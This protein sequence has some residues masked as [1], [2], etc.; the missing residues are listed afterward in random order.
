MCSLEKQDCY[1][2]LKVIPLSLT[3]SPNC[4]KEVSFLVEHFKAEPYKNLQASRF[5]ISLPVSHSNFRKTGKFQQGGHDSHKHFEDEPLIMTY[6]L[7]L[8]ISHL[9]IP[10]YSLMLVLQKGMLTF[11]IIWISKILIMLKDKS[12]L[13]DQMKIQCGCPFMWRS[14]LWISVIKG[15]LFTFISIESTYKAIYIERIL[16]K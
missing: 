8:Q 14:D 1:F 13:W 11:C 9:I 15:G 2:Q 5:A 4:V 10:L 3:L 12:S 16:Y 6:I 7:C